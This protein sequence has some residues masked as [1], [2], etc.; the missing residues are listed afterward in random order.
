MTAYIRSE[1]EPEMT[2]KPQNNNISS[3]NYDGSWVTVKVLTTQKEFDELES[4][5]NKLLNKPEVEADIFQTFEWQRLWWKNFGDG[6]DLQILTVWDDQELVG[7]A[8]LFIEKTSILG[9][10]EYK[11]LKLIGSSISDNDAAN[12][13]TDGTFSYYLDL[14][15][16]PDYRDEV[17]NEF[18]IY[19]ERT[20]GCVDAIVMDEFSE[21]ST[22]LN[23]VLLKVW[24]YGWKLDG[25]LKEESTQITLSEAIEE[26][27]QNGNYNDSPNN[28]FRVCQVQSMEELDST[29]DDFVGLHQKQWNKRGYPGL[30]G[31]SKFKGFLREVA[32]IFAEK[33]KLKMN[34]ALDS[35]GNCVAVNISFEF[36]DRVYNYQKAFDKEDAFKAL[37]DFLIEDAVRNDFQYV[38]L[39]R[40]KE[41]NLRRYTHQTTRNLQ[42]VISGYASSSSVKEYLHRLVQATNTMREQLEKEWMVL[43]IHINQWGFSGFLPHY[44]RFMR[45]RIPPSFDWRGLSS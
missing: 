3:M 42:V 17:V 11:E 10:Y 40:D 39:L 43:K 16:H 22:I 6:N 32:H 7:L 20:R 13:L 30:F 5:W 44:T 34:Q 23:E 37:T 31:D 25:K 9:L 28:Q 33:G 14:I 41:N 2:T 26:Y 45:K 1:S 15:I 18:I 38:D 4:A 19:L 36:K 21:E 8:P 35:S 27:Q 24:Q 29:F 12:V